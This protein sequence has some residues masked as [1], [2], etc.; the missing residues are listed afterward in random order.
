LI[1]MISVPGGKFTMGSPR[2]TANSLPIERPVHEVTV[3]SFLIGKYE[4]TQGDYF[5]VTGDRPSS[6]FTN[7]ED[8][9]NPE[10]WKKLPVEMVTWYDSLVFCNRLS[11]RERLDPVYRIR[12]ST[13]PDDWGTPPTARRAEWDSV[14]MIS[15]A[16]GYRLP[17]ESEW[18][19]AARGG[20]ES[21]GFNYAGSNTIGPVAWF[22]DNAN[23][24]IREVGKKEP[25]ELGLYDMSGNAM[26]WCWDWLDDYT[27]EPRDNPV[28]PHSGQ[29]RVIRG[30]GWSVSHHFSRVAYRHN[31]L[32]HYFGVNLGFR[33]VRSQ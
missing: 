22:F 6:H 15:G 10:G 9:E 11:I 4:V 33:V 7:P 2:G 5:E 27:A 32:P 20:E 30:G 13:N 1:E 3:R 16:N 25:N 17:T 26:E 14:E 19:F 29:Y 12:G 31:N 28:G 8:E 18:E 24:R 23:M 21:K